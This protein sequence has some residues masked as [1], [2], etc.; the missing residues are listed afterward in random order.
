MKLVDIL[1][2]TKELPIIENPEILEYN[3]II[4]G[5]SEVMIDNERKEIWFV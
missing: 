2:L 5:T 3:V 1:D 4:S